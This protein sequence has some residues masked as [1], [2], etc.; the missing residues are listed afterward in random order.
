MTIELKIEVLKVFKLE[1]SMSS[2]NKKK[3]KDNAKEGDTDQP[4]DKQSGGR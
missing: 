4:A 3:V 2:E 1:F